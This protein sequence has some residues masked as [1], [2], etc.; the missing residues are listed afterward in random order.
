[1]GDKFGLLSVF[2]QRLGFLGQRQSVLAQNVA[3][4]DTPNYVPRDLDSKAFE[5]LV[6]GGAPQVRTS[7]TR[8]GH[9]AGT[10]EEGGR[11]RPEEQRH[12]YETLP[13]G[14]AVVLEEQL[15]KVADTN[16]QH[17]TVTNLYGKYMQMFKTAVG[18]SQG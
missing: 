13:S 16:I 5:R 1:M 2:S 7:V 17:A 6:R 3:N 12:R 14:N 15:G 11:F 8:S 10:L 18:R 9:L 4:A